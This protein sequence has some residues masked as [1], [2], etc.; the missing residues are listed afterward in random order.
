MKL[1]ITSLLLMTTLMTTAQNG[2]ATTIKKTFS[3]STEV[4]IDIAADPAIVWALLTNAEDFPRWNSTVL[5]IEGDIKTGQKILL[6]SYLDPSRTFKIK[7][8]EMQPGQKM[9]WGDGLGKRTFTLKKIEG[10]THFNMYEKM[11][12]LMFPLFSSKIPDFA[13]SFEK[14]AQ[15]LKVEAE[16]IAATK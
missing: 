4:G 2:R 15:D 8:K 10:G 16:S 13:E 12:N 9:V 3:R 5:S 6:K 1:H 11:G 14:Y 7:V